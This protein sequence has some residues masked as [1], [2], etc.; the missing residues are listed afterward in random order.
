MNEYDVIL[1]HSFAVPRDTAFRTVLANADYT[2]STPNYPGNYPSD[3]KLYWVL[4]AAEGDR[5]QMNFEAFALSL[6][7]SVTVSFQ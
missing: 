5:I 3:T 4:T 6:D 1:F 2:L 7:D